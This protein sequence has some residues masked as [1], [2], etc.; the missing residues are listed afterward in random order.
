[1]A[2]RR[3]L[4]IGDPIPGEKL[5]PLTIGIILDPPVGHLLVDAEH[6]YLHTYWNR[7]IKEQGE[8]G[9]E[10]YRKVLTHHGGSNG[11][12][13]E[14]GIDQHQ[15]VTGNIMGVETEIETPEELEGHLLKPPFTLRTYAQALR[16]GLNIIEI[17]GER[18]WMND[19]LY[20]ID[21]TIRGASYKMAAAELNSRVTNLA[22]LHP[23]FDRA[24]NPYM[25]S[26]GRHLNEVLAA[27]QGDQRD[28]AMRALIEMGRDVNQRAQEL[29]EILEATIRREAI[30][31]R[32]RNSMEDVVR[33]VHGKVTKAKED[34]DS[35]ESDEQRQKIIA[36][37]TNLFGVRR[38]A[39]ELKIQPFRGRAERPVLKRLARVGEYYVKGDTERVGRVLTE[40]EKELIRWKEQIDK[41]VKGEYQL[42]YPTKT[43]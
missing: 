12:V 27:T 40:G 35:T 10:R 14:K 39:D 19:C 43:T 6:G 8:G 7:W 1:M 21:R 33:D 2:E 42:R 29:T 41:R 24:R 13:I 3:L 32:Y 34:W 20:L 5:N 37:A 11:M 15:I 36:Q 31:E 28:D 17:P 26:A 9:K 22:Q 23:K 4:Q 18:R 25:E 30:L 16:I 38:L